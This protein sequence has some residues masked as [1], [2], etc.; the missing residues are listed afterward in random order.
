M[1]GIQ[2]IIIYNTVTGHINN[3]GTNANH[4]DGN[5]SVSAKE[6]E[7]VIRIDD[8]TELAQKI[9][10]AKKYNIITEK[11]ID[12]S[13][14]ID[15]NEIISERYEFRDVEVVQTRQEYRQSLNTRKKEILRE[16]EKSDNQLARLIDDLTEFAETLGFKPNANKKTLI[17]QRKALRQELATLD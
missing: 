8:N 12:V 6:N 1:E 4:Q 17:Q 16:L 5:I 2:M 13:M 15:G 11:V 3:L 10:S 9:K 14:D 7:I